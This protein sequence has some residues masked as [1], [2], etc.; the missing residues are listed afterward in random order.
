MGCSSAREKIESKILS[1]KLERVLIKQ[2][3]KKQIAQLEK[4]TGQKIKREKVPDYIDPEELKRIKHLQN[5]F[6][7]S[8]EE[9]SNINENE[10]EEEEEEN[11]EEEKEN[12]KQKKK[13][14]INENESDN[15]ENNLNIA[16]NHNKKYINSSEENDE[17]EIN[18]SKKKKKKKKLRN[19]KEIKKLDNTLLNKDISFGQDNTLF[20]NKSE[21][22]EIN[23]IKELDNNDDKKIND[24][25]T[26]I[27]VENENK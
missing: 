21:N 27:S 18:T 9:S 22:I 6:L 3:K 2:E 10:N 20:K 7:N 24:E 13:S 26:L 19:N 17:K 16:D 5:N 25:K 23:S 12:K 1:L 14:I 8:E 15:E 11:E 4:M